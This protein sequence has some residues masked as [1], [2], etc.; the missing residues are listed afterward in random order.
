M[1]KSELRTVLCEVFRYDSPGLEACLG[2]NVKCC[3]QQDVFQK[4]LYSGA[5][6]DG[7]FLHS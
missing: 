2:S 1:L 4:F 6:S 7:A 3:C 5:K